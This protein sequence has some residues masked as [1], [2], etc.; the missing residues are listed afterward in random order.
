[1]STKYLPS[2]NWTHNI[3][4]RGASNCSCWNLILRS[5]WQAEVNNYKQSSLVLTSTNHEE[6]PK[7]TNL[8]NCQAATMGFRFEE[9]NTDAKSSKGDSSAISTIS[10]EGRGHTE[11]SN[12]WHGGEVCISL[13]ELKRPSKSFGT[14]KFH[15]SISSSPAL[16]AA[17][18]ILSSSPSLVA[19][20]RV[21]LGVGVNRMSAAHV[22][23]VARLSSSMF[24]F[25]I[26]HTF[27]GTL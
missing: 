25:L 16:R 24:S 21:T 7:Y 20:S 27:N 5:P 22:A 17:F 26:P 12:K 23:H 10:R 2:C 14:F 9:R 1:M 15:T 19:A 3:W 11:N 4:F 6:V 18:F 13:L 8:N